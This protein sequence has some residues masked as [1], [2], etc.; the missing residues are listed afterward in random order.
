[1]GDRIFLNRNMNQKLSV[2]SSDEDWLPSVCLNQGTAGTDGMSQLV[3]L[4]DSWPFVN[5]FSSKP[6]LNFWEEI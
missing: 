6:I 3:N 4:G 1:M 2:A 5:N